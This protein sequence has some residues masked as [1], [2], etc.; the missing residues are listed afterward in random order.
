L[1]RRIPAPKS[2]SYPWSDIDPDRRNSILLIA[3][4][5]LIIVF[6]IGLIGYGY[7]SERVAPQHAS[8]IQVGHREFNYAF[9]ERRAKAE[10]IRGR[11]DPNDLG[12]A[13]FAL[14]QTIQREEVIRQAA[15]SL[16][17]RL[18]GLE[19]EA[20]Y[21]K[22]L[23]VSGEESRDQLAARLR[24]ELL[25]LG[26]T[27]SDYGD[28]TSANLLEQKLRSHFGDQ[29]PAE[30]VHL[31][32]RLIQAATQAD[33]LKAKDR[34]DAGD[35]FGVV[36]VDLSAHPQAKQNAGDLSWTPRGVIS[37]EVQEV[38][39]SLAIGARSGI[40]ET[41]E[42]FFIVQVNGKE[43]RPVT[44]DGKKAIIQR[45]LDEQLRLTRDETNADITMT[46]KQ[47]Q[48]LALTLNAAR[49]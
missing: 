29:A 9:V 49:V 48:K 17:I 30:T 41:R 25:R 45:G 16:D 39:E 20:A 5:V 13:L 15:K 42:A 8:V 24:A 10:Q 37:K 3:G 2:R 22:Q 34:L 19:I 44:E 31:Y 11:L 21:R 12:S 38:A 14:L 43:T 33:A 40:I 18:G 7:Y 32:L 36:A 28:I 4:I 46:T 26:L 6:A 27:L 35:S 47:V 23:V 1:S